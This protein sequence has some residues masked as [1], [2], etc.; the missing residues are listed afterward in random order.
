MIPKKN[1]NQLSGNQSPKTL[2]WQPLIPL[3]ITVEE[4]I[5]PS[6]RSQVPRDPKIDKEYE[7]FVPIKKNCPGAFNRPSFDGT[8]KRTEKKCRDNNR[9]GKDGNPVKTK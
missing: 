3:Q 5:N 7:S 1:T 8:Y 4:P 9:R 2:H 6:F